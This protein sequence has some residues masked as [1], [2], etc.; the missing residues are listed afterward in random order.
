HLSVVI[1]ALLAAGGLWFARSAW[2]ASA[3]DKSSTGNGPKA[4]DGPPKPGQRLHSPA[5]L[6]PPDPTRRFRDFTPEQRVEF[7]RKGH[8]PG[9]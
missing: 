7:A 6:A 2:H 8:G 9:G 3:S 1:A 5:R 4:S